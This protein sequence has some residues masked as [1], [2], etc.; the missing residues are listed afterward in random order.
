MTPEAFKSRRLKLISQMRQRGGGVAVLF[1]APEVPRNRDSDF[2]FRWDSYFYYLSGF[3]EPEAAVVLIVTEDSER[4]LLFCREK[5]ELREI[6]DGFRYGPAAAKEVFGFDE[7]HSIASLNEEAP[8][9]LANAPA[10]YYSLGIDTALD[11]KVQGWL[12]AVRAQARSGVCAPSQAFDVRSLL[13]EMRLIKDTSEIAT[14]R[15]A[16][17]ISAQA[18]IR[19]MQHCKPGQF[20]YE[21]EAELLYVFKK[22]GSQFPA[23]SSIVAAGRNACV[24][25]YRENNAKMR[26][27]DLLLIDA[28]CELDGYASDITRTFPVNGKFSGGQKA[29]Y[30]IVLA[31]QHAATAA[32]KPG[33]SFID[34]HNAAVRVLTQGLID[35]KL[36][37]GPLDEAIDKQRFSRFYMHRTSHW[38]GMDVHDCGDYRETLSSGQKLKAAQK[39]KTGKKLEAGPNMAA[40]PEKPWRVLKPG[41]VL[42]IEPGLYVSAA[43]DV[44]QHFHNIGIRIEDDALVTDQ[45]CELISADVP[46]DLANIESLMR[47]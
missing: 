7:A 19:A 21:V 31:S 46:T 43:H 14:M 9:L 8:K 1:T 5:N 27:G 38:L 40:G 29:L 22:G 13:D 37:E 35:C 30:E 4:S 2:P 12:N 6:W 32:T 3:P 17:K 39:A 42:T 36:I 45:G 28:G 11:Q 25:H 34:P 10:I 26:D 15:R 44:P 23:Y 24:L 33:A 47:A 16:A 41:M 18:H 20:E